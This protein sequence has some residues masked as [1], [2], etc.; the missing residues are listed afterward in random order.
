MTHPFAT[1]E[2]AAIFNSFTAPDRR[3]LLTLRDLIFTTAATT[4]QITETLKWGVPSYLPAKPRTGTTLR[5]GPH[6][7]GGFALFAH[8]QTS[9][10]PQFRDQF[11]TAFAYDGNR[12][13]IFN[14]PSEIDETALQILIHRALTYHLK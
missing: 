5:L 6:K 2:I 10:I 12:A 14:H 8:C 11:G 7:G 9:L 4:T 1:P 13:V 3:G